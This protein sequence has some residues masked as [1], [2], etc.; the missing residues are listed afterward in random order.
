MRNDVGDVVYTVPIENGLLSHHALRAYRYHLARFA[1]KTS[2]GKK[3][4][5]R[6]KMPAG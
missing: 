2:R 5:R 4:T 3:K 1:L 6:G